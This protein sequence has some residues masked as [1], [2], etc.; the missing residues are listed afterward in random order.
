[1]KTVRSALIAALGFFALVAQTLLFRDFLSC[2]SGNEL[3][4]G[5]FFGAWLFW[6][7]IGALAG[8]FAC[9]KSGAI[10][11]RFSV[12]PLLYIPA[13][14]IQ[15]ALIVNARAL[16]GVESFV[17]VP[18]PSIFLAALFF[19]A[20]ISFLTGFLFTCAC[21][22]RES[23]SPTPVSRVFIMEAYGGFL[24]GLF[25]TIAL[26]F[27]MPSEN[28]FLLSS[29]S[30]IAAV[31]PNIL[32]SGRKRNPRFAHAVIILLSFLLT[33]MCAYFIGDWWAAK[34]DRAQWAKLLPGKFYEG[35]FAT[36]Q[37]KYL[38]GVREEQFILMNSGGVV[39]TLPE[40]E[41]ASEI[42]AIALSQ[43]PD[44]KRVLLVGPGGLGIALRLAI[45]PRMDRPVWLYPDPELPG[46]LLDALPDS[47]RRLTAT[48]E[49]QDDEPREYLRKNSAKFDIVVLN[50]PEAMTLALNRYT[51]REFF[52]LVKANLH[53]DGVCLVRVTGG[54]NY[55]GPELAMLGASALSTLQSVFPHVLLKPGEESYLIASAKGRLSDSPQELQSRFSS[56]PGASLMYPPQGF[57]TLFEKDRVDFQTGKYRRAMMNYPKSLLLNS[58]RNPKALLHHLLVALRRGGVGDLTNIVAILMNRGLWILLCGVSVYAACRVVYTVRSSGLESKKTS[59]FSAYDPQAIVLCAGFVGMATGIAL[60]FRFQSEFGSLYLHIGL[61][62]SFVMAGTA[63]GG[64]VCEKAIHGNPIAPRPLLAIVILLHIVFLGACL[65]LGGTTSRAMFSVFFFLCGVFIGIYFPLAAQIL[66]E[67]GRDDVTTGARLELLD[68]WGGAAGAMTTGLLFLPIMGATRAI[69][70]FAALVAAVALPAVAIRGG[71]KSEAGSA[72]RYDAFSRPAGYILFGIGSFL[73]IASQIVEY[74]GAVSEHEEFQ[75]LASQMAAGMGIEETV[76]KRADGAPIEYD[77]VRNQAGVTEGYLFP[78]TSLAPCVNG[79]GGEIRLAVLIDAEG[80]LKEFRILRSHE[81]PAY[82]LFL[83][84]WFDALKGRN[85]LSAKPF[86]GVDGVSGATM[87]SNAVMRILDHSAKSFGSEILGRKIETTAEPMKSAGT[88]Q[89]LAFVVLTAAALFLRFRPGVWRRRLFLMIALA[90]FGLIWNLQYSTHHAMSLVSVRIPGLSMSGPLFLALFVPVIV[91]LFGNV[92]CG[93]LCPFGAAQELAGDLRPSRWPTDPG[94]LVWRYGRFVKYALLFVLTSLFA[95]TRDSSVLRA[96]PL[97]TIFGA[98][99]DL[100]LIAIGVAAL[101]ISFFFRRF[102]CR[103]LCPAGAFLSLLN[104]IRLLKRFFPAP[105]PTACDLGV[106]SHRDLDCIHCD[107]CRHEEK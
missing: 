68:H 28:V 99:R 101:A 83:R 76:A 4:V 90:L 40:S 74:A 7:G 5:A 59:S 84:S 67:T 35:S 103:N 39:E 26:A 95:L 27:G 18:L 91:V 87:T 78:T 106:R 24:G 51:T 107:R 56:I 77:I 16:I 32:F 8:R 60:M 75:K 81:T 97:T 89:F 37:G 6:V 47:S 20:F 2:L 10:V 12:L 46:R 71:T 96:D 66:R 82:L 102:W 13:C 14:L 98:A 1:M 94:K 41:H 93:Y 3:A 15:R 11:A 86:E 36:A 57:A 54:A 22:W 9:R 30:L 69:L 92:Y 72:D 104:G 100:L 88:I 73:L 61:I 31:A 53:E 19:N 105:R 17:A 45:L 38:F 63:L 65:G 64:L 34:A 44:A 29:L 85:L 23:E 33:G 80:A 55:L 43:K 70:F 49:T 50:L 79:Y 58:D 52:E 62:A 21:A 42:A 25:V 48:V